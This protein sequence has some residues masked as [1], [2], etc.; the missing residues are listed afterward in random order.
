MASPDAPT[1]Q[2]EPTPPD[3]SRTTFH[4]VFNQKQLI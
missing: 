3:F 1:G 2:A 4:L